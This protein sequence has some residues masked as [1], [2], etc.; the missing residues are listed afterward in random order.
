MEE[1]TAWQNRPLEPCYPVVFLDAIRVNIRSDGAVS[2]KAVFVA[3]AILADGTRDVLGLW[4]QANEGA[5]FWAKVLNDLRNRGVQDIL[6]AVVDGLKG[7]P[8]AIEAAF[9]QTQVQTCIVH[10]L[11]HSTSFASDKD[12]K[13]VAVALKAIYTA[14]DAAAAETA[15]AQFEDSDL[16]AR[17]PAIGQSWR[18]AWEHV[19]PLFAFPPDI[20]KMIY[21]TDEMDKTGLRKLCYLG[22]A[23]ATPWRRVGPRLQVPPG[24]LVTACRIGLPD[25]SVRAPLASSPTGQ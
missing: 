12:R 25:W 5:K 24:R 19:I 2:N 23:R 6:I 8:Q 10:L 11:R 16:D 14:I 9:P 13:A 22:G 15:L 1:V 18:R 21:T 20:R 4:F 17:Y 7:F 3:L